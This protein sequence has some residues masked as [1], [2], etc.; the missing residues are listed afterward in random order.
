MVSGKRIS[1]LSNEQKQPEVLVLLQGR[2]LSTC[3]AYRFGIGFG[4]PNAVQY[5]WDLPELG[6]K[7][8]RLQATK[9]MM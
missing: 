4:I 6:V 3:E 7:K 5:V 2:C 8:D 1:F 9:I